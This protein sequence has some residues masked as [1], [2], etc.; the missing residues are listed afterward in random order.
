MTEQTPPDDRVEPSFLADERAMLDGWLDYHRRTLIW[1]CEGLSDEQVKTASVPPSKMTLIGLVRHMSE[2]ER[3]WFAGFFGTDETEI[4]CTPD[5]REAEW[6]DV[7]DADVA[8]DI[9][10]LRREIE[11]YREHAARSSLDDVQPHSTG[12]DINLR[13]IYTH[14]I[15]EYA[16][17]NGHADLIRERIDGATGD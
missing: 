6:D 12:R 13:W 11:T 1:K 14:M 8:A 10:T 2:V 9:A 16:R 5:N 4:Y 7:A 17:H 3:G 15:E